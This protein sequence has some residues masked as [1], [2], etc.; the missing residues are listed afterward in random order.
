MRNSLSILILSFVPVSAFASVKDYQVKRLIMMKSDYVEQGLAR[1]EAESGGLIFI[2]QCEN[3]S[4]YSD[5]VK[6]LCDDAEDERSCKLKTKAKS[7][8]HLRLL[9]SN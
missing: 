7:Y 5:G 4:H 3:L 1:N 8:D 2:A 9:Q 6:V